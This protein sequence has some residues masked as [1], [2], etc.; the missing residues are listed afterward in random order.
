M[1]SEAEKF[2]EEDEKM[3]SAVYAKNDLESYIYQMKAMVRNPF[4][5]FYFYSHFNNLKRNEIIKCE[6]VGRNIFYRLLLFSNL[7]SECRKMRLHTLREL[8]KSTLT[9]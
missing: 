7:V 9:S 3:R 2:R 6:E 8:R 5:L 1:V 4:F